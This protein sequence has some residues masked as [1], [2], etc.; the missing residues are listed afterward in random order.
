MQGDREFIAR[1]AAV[2]TELQRRPAMSRSRAE[3]N[4]ILRRYILWEELHK[5]M[6]WRDPGRAAA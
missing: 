3:R 4:R 2:G 6:I 5:F 1:I